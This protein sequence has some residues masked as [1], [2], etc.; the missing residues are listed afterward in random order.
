VK[1]DE[2]VIGFGSERMFS[3][4]VRDHRR[5]VEARPRRPTNSSTPSA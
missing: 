4:F 1:N 3:P 2:I 5:L